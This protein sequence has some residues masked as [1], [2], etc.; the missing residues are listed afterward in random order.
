MKD[1]E[2]LRGREFNMVLIE[3]TVTRGPDGNLQYAMQDILTDPALDPAVF[4]QKCPCGA[5][6]RRLGNDGSPHCLRC[7][8]DLLVAESK[9]NLTITP[10]IIYTI[11]PPPDPSN[12]ESSA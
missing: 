12:T 6:G 5:P 4:A 8:F 10:K 7:Y 2:K 9:K 11:K 1:I 3:E